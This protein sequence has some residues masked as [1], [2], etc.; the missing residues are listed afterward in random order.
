[1]L[2]DKAYARFKQRLFDGDLKPGQFVSQRELCAVVDM[3][4]GPVR[5]ALKRLQAEAL[6][7]VIP[8]RGIQIADVNVKL[9]RDAF[10]LRTTLELHAVRR[11][12][13]S[14][15]LAALDAVEDRMRSI[16]VRARRRFTAEL[17][18]DFIRADLAMH[19]AL[20]ANLGNDLIAETYRVNADR[21]LLMQLT[22]RLDASRLASAIAEHMVV[23]A[24]L[25]RRD[26]D[27]AAAALETHLKAA[28]RKMLGV[29]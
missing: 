1:M 24:A 28:Q 29:A 19:Q 26:A 18:R 8:Q 21:I 7:K 25:R 27:G 23:L 6:V 22:S 12:A 3:K 20:I 16:D 5:D 4:V 9:L 14:G 10:E 2:R 15:D 17:G 11:Y 13:Q